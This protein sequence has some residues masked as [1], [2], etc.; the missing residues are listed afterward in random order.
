MFR[1]IR[2][3]NLIHVAGIRY[4]SSSKR[5]PRR[6]E[7]RHTQPDLDLQILYKAQLIRERLFC[8]SNSKSQKVYCIH[9]SRSCSYDL[10][11]NWKPAIDANAQSKPQFHGNKRQLSNRGWSGS[12]CSNLLLCQSAFKFLWSSL[13]ASAWQCSETVSL[14]CCY[15]LVPTISLPYSLNSLVK[16][17]A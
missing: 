11:P 7:S 10:Q 15:L 14:K 1:C 5:N 16:P 12:L 9:V 3:C 4:K 8:H 13:R 17:F 2:T 6:P